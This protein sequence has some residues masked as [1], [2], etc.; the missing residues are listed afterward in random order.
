MEINREENN[1]KEKNE[2]RMCSYFFNNRSDF[3][4]TIDFF[5]AFYLFFLTFNLSNYCIHQLK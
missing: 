4:I 1:Q 5:D 3:I 2:K